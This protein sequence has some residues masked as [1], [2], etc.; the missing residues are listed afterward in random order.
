MQLIPVG[1]SILYV[2]PFY[3]AG[4]RRRAASRSSS[5][6]SCYSQDYGAVLRPDGAATALDQMLGAASRADHVQRVGGTHR[7][8]TGDRHGDDHDDADQPPRRRTTPATTPTDHHDPA[9]DRERSR[10]SLDQAAARLDQAQTALEAGDLGH[11]PDARRRRPGTLV[12]QA[13]QQRA[14]G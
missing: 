14:G 9:G 10:S 8:A 11:V 12:K 6:S 2:R 5:S 13:Q 4:P 7:A 3:V 1:N